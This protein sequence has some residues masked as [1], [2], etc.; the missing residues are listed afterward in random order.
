MAKLSA[1][2]KGSINYTRLNREDGFIVTN[3]RWMRE[4]I[5]TGT[6]PTMIDR[7]RLYD[8]KIPK[9]TPA[10][11]VQVDCNGEIQ[12]LL[13]NAYNI[14]PNKSPSV[15]VT[16][17]RESLPKIK[18][19]QLLRRIPHD[20]VVEFF[21]KFITASI[22]EPMITL[23]CTKS[24]IN[25]GPRRRLFYPYDNTA[26]MKNVYLCLMGMCFMEMRQ[27]HVMKFPP[28]RQ[29]SFKRLNCRRIIV[30]HIFPNS[31]A[32]TSE[33]FGVS[34]IICK[35]NGFDLYDMIQKHKRGENELDP[36]RIF[37]NMILYCLQ[38][39][40]SIT[41]TNQHN[42]TF[43]LSRSKIEEENRQNEQQKYYT[44]ENKFRNV[45]NVP[46]V[47]TE[48]GQKELRQK[49]N[50]SEDIITKP[51]LAKTWTSAVKREHAVLEQRRKNMKN[52]MNNLQ[53]TSSA[54]CK[55]LN[56]MMIENL[57]LDANE[58]QLLRLRVKKSTQDT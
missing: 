38:T 4:G 24:F 1:W 16:M 3:V 58:Q 22:E 43:T 46:V 54:D 50:I 47:L 41:L 55:I 33:I 40:E 31:T 9:G 57:I 35:I 5:T 25:R 56:E 8:L 48:A 34:N 51:S 2:P 44:Q 53:K 42:E 7:T 49:Y 45:F 18:L 11:G 12:M 14:D 10:Q 52:K 36:I 20:C 13:A 23:R 19:V 26:N 29:T 17:K 28:L 15:S 21:G 37:K 27:Q 32:Y 6:T 30:T 39:S